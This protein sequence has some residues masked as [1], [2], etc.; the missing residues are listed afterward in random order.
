[1]PDQ[2]ARAAFFWRS[3]TA[4]TNSSLGRPFF[5]ATIRLSKYV[6]ICGFFGLIQKT[7]TEMSFRVICMM[8]LHPE[9]T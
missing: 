2:L 1:M 5:G 7:N 6:V 4:R 9:E 3:R 8:T